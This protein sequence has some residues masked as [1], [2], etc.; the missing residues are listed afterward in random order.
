VSELSAMPAYFHCSVAPCK[1]FSA[2]PTNGCLFG[3][4]GLDLE[5]GLSERWTSASTSQM[6]GR[7]APETKVSGDLYFRDFWLNFS[8]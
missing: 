7:P 8:R 1:N 2:V 3:G 6:L 4:V 5:L